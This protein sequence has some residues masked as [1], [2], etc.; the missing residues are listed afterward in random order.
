GVGPRDGKPRYGRVI[1]CKIEQREVANAARDG[2]RRRRPAVRQRKPGAA[3]PPG[4]MQCT[5][6]KAR[7]R[8]RTLDRYSCRTKPID[9]RRRN[10]EITVQR[11]LGRCRLRG[12]AS[13]KWLFRAARVVVEPAPRLAP[14]PP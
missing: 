6:R 3:R 14:Q 9:Q 7:V 2:A 11:D 8:A 4:E 12:L 1:V 5:R 10:A 13:R